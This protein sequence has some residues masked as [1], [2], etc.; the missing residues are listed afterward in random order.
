MKGTSYWSRFRLFSEC[1]QVANI[2][3]M[4]TEKARTRRLPVTLASG[5]LDYLAKLVP[6]GTHGTSIPDVAK[7]LIEEG[8]R[9]A[10][11]DGIL[12]PTK[13]PRSE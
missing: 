2:R 8:V 6:Q 3:Y 13:T 12:Q 5:T 7:T 4:A 11:R 9:R 10:I 1:T